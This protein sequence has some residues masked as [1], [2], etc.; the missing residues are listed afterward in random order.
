M[1]L[2]WKNEKGR[3]LEAKVK[4]SIGF[5]PGMIRRYQILRGIAYV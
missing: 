1:S 4:R 5:D 3:N 2:A